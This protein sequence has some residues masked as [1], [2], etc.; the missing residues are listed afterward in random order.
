MPDR[1]SF[2]FGSGISIRAGM[3]TV[4]QITEKILSGNGVMRHTDEQYYIRS[5]DR[6]MIGYVE[7]VVA[8]L[9]RLHAEIKGYYNSRDYYGS[10]SGRKINYEEL[11]YVALQMYESETGAHDNPIVQAFIDR[12]LPDIEPLFVR[13]DS[14]EIERIWNLRKIAGEA[15]HYIQDLVSNLL[16]TSTDVSYLSGVGNACKELDV[17]PRLFTL[18]HDTVLERFLNESGIPYTDGMEAPENGYRYWSPEVFENCDHKIRLFKLH[19]SW[20]WFR[21]QSSVA[22]GGNDPVGIAI[23]GRYWLSKNQD[24]TYQWRDPGRSIML[25]G[26]F[27]KIEEYTDRIF[28]DLFCQFRR[29]LREIDLLIVCG[30]GFGDQGINRQIWEWAESSDRPRMVVIHEKPDDLAMGAR[31]YIS[32]NWDRWLRDKKLVIVRKWI[33]DTSWKD[34]QDAIQR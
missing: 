14:R 34:I 16:R 4:D 13:K 1:V 22:T 8:F 10:D 25:V 2:L 26:T 20:N 7:R 31:A 3:P 27:N 12:I 17:P 19:G 30:Y 24:G 11:Y 9:N 32:H 15:I 28:A 23:D 5:P 18:N 21:Y 6:V 29:A 33:Q